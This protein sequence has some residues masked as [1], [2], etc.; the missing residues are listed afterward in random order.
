MIKSKAFSFTLA[1]LGALALPQTSFA[2]G[3]STEMGP[4]DTTLS[5]KGDAKKG[6]RYFAQCRACHKLTSEP[7]HRMG[8]NLGGLF[9]RTAGTAEGYEKRYSKALRDAGFVWTEEKLNEWL[10]A[11]RTFLPGNKMTYGGMRKEQMRY[12]LLAYLRT[13]TEPKTESKEEK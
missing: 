7:K 8:P 6:S 12:D 2:A 3:F 10:K 11:P 5:S 4:E 9:G 13:A 1:I